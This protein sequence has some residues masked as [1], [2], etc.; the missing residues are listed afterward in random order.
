MNFIK[1]FRGVFV[2]IGITA[3][4]LTIS[5]YYTGKQNLGAEEQTNEPVLE[6]V[7]EKTV[8][9]AETEIEEI[10]T[11]LPVTLKTSEPDA[12]IEVKEESV[13]KSTL[14]CFLTVRCDTLLGNMDSLAPEKIHLIPQDGLILTEIEFEFSEGESAFDALERELKRRKIHFEFTKNSMYDS[15]YIEGIGGLYEFDAG[16]LSG[17]IYRVNGEILS[18]GCSQ[19]KLKSGDKI[20]FLYTCNMGKDL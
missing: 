4:V 2:V 15:A 12:E 7:S 14:S 1:K 13:E 17:W 8:D 11:P 19:Y 20:E 18:V 6:D 16:D 3:M 5:F 10:I 9:Y